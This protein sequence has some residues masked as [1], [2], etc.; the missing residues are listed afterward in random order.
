LIAPGDY[1]RD[2]A[3]EDLAAQPVRRR[4]RPELRVVHHDATPLAE[5]RRGVGEVDAVATTQGERQIELLPKQSRTLADFFQRDMIKRDRTATTLRREYRDLDVTIDRRQVTGPWHG[6]LR[7]RRAASLPTQQAEICRE[8]R[9]QQE[10][11]GLSHISR[12]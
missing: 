10:N 2:D 5:N 12:R 11:A 4:A 3:I 1:R 9:F 7:A 8:S 6:S